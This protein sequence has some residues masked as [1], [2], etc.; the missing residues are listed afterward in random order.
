MKRIKMFIKTLLIVGLMSGTIALLLGIFVHYLIYNP[1][2]LTTALGCAL[3]TALGC[4]I[5][6]ALIYTIYG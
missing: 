1:Y 5:T 2:S 6:N 4:G 3:G